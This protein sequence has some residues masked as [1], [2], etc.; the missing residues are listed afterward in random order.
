MASPR[1]TATP[2]SPSTPNRKTTVANLTPLTSYGFRVS[3]T[4]AAGIPAS[5][6]RS[7]TSSSAEEVVAA[8]GGGLRPAACPPGIG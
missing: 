3:L 2:S 5:G 8:A 6:A 4:N 1:S 7:C